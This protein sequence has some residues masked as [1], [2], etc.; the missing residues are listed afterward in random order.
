[1]HSLNILGIHVY[2]NP[3]LE[4]CYA[5]LDQELALIPGQSVVT[6]QVAKQ[7]SGSLL[8]LP[9]IREFMKQIYSPL[10]SPVNPINFQAQAA[11]SNTST[12]TSVFEQASNSDVCTDPTLV[13]VA[14]AGYS[15]ATLAFAAI[16][17]TGSAFALYKLDQSQNRA[18]LKYT[19]AKHLET[20]IAKL[21]TKLETASPEDKNTVIA[22]MAIKKAALQRLG[23]SESHLLRNRVKATVTSMVN[24]LGGCQSRI[25]SAI[26]T[27]CKAGYT[28]IAS[29]LRVV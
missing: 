15:S 27:N 20:E 13:P 4:P 18:A 12:A 28:A 7:A 11:A 16:A 26:L 2:C 24:S 22:E 10:F 19:I 29:K 14:S 5:S 23:S 17:I 8:R 6:H 1:M 25:S 9:P 3:V 21:Q